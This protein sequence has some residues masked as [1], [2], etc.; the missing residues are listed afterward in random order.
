ML[1][2]SEVSIRCFISFI[3]CGFLEEFLFMIWI[4][5]LLFECNIIDVL[6][7]FLFYIFIV[8]IIGKNFLIE[9]WYFN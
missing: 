9:M 4:I 3:K 8:S 5:V 1:Y 6:D 2:F 7:K